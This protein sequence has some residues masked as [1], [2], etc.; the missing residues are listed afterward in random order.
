MHLG[1]LNL[2]RLIF[3]LQSIYLRLHMIYRFL[4][5]GQFFKQR[6]FVALHLAQLLKDFTTV[7][8]LLF[9][10]LLLLLSCLLLV[11]EAASN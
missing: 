9:K 8:C 10:F 4:R 11:F 7:R 1:I 5:L 3:V 2:C 6:C